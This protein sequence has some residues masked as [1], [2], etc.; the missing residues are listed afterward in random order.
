MVRGWWV[1]AGLLLVP[2]F[3]TAQGLTVLVVDER[4]RP[5]EGAQGLVGELRANSGADGL[6]RFPALA[7]GR[8][9]L[10]TRF[11]GYRPDIREVVVTSAGPTRLTVTLDPTPLMLPPVVVEATR[12]GLFGIVSTTRL[13]PLPG[14]EIQLL[15]RRGRT[16]RA[17]SAGH[18]MHP[19]AVGSYLVRISARGYEDRRLGVTVPEGGGQE[20]L[21]HLYD[22]A[23]GYQGASNQEKWNLQD[24]S[25]RLAWAN[26]RQVLTRSDLEKYGVRSICEVPQLASTVTRMERLNAEALI[27]GNFAVPNPCAIRAHE[28]Q[29]IE[30]GDNRCASTAMGIG[31]LF[32]G[33][34]RAMPEASARAGV[35]RRRISR[36]LPYLSVWTA[37]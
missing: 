9:R 36:C 33:K 26:P 14:A 20:V 24:L 16:L 35:V 10:I 5:V 22:A 32:R 23:P 25:F 29:V 4:A 1:I 17:D 30:W 2:G 3:L 27:D 34:A 31:E 37:K 12:P 6:I 18:F 21:I 7:P 11:I 19:E 13:E 28:V 8:Y 15:G